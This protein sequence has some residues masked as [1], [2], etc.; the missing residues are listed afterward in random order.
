MNKWKVTAYTGTGS[1]K[2]SIHDVDES[3]ALTNAKYAMLTK[4]VVT[5]KIER[6]K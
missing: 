2:L 6:E 1:L 3:D 4:D 5:V